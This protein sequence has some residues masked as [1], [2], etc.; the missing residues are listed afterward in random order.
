MSPY[1]RPQSTEVRTSTNLN[2]FFSTSSKPFPKYPSLVVRLVHEQG[3][4]ACPVQLQGYAT[5][6]IS[7]S[8]TSTRLLPE[9][10]SVVTIKLMDLKI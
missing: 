5:I 9:K 7:D 10:F 8:V 2:A 1:R 4:Y 6:D 3:T